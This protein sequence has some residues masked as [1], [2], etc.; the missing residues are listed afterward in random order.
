MLCLLRIRLSDR[1][2]HISTPSPLC[3][4]LNFLIALLLVLTKTYCGRLHALQAF[5]RCLCLSF[6]SVLY[7]TVSTLW[8]RA[9]IN[10]DF[11]S[12]SLVTGHPSKDV[13][14]EV[15]TFSDSLFKYSL[16]IL[17]HH[18]SAFLFYSTVMLA[19]LTKVFLN[20]QFNV[21]VPLKTFFWQVQRKMKLMDPWCNLMCYKGIQYMGCK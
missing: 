20:I 5:L 6:T 14:S 7:D 15:A 12:P 18:I 19:S 3:I 2:H 1:S 11:P 13:F 9:L 8:F 10:P 21:C 17:L 16:T 4:G